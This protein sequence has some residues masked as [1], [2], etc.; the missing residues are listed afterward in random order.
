METPTLLSVTSP[1]AVA[2][3]GSMEF[4]A[5]AQAQ[6]CPSPVAAAAAQ[7]PRAGS[8]SDATSSACDAA[9]AKGGTRPER[10]ARFEA[11]VLVLS[12]LLLALFLSI[13]L[14]PDRPDAS[15]AAAVLLITALW[16]F[17]EIVPLTISSLL[18]LVLYPLLGVVKM[19]ELASRYFSGTSFLFVAGFFIGLAI[20]RWGLH[21]HF[22]C[23]IVSRAGSRIEFLIAGFMVSVWLLSM[24]ISNTAT[25]LCM[26]PVARGFL[27]T[28]PAGHEAFQG[29][30]LLAMGY[31]ATIGGIAT[32][33]GTPTNG[34]FMEQFEIFWPS[35]GEFS[36][37]KFFL[38][39]LPLSFVLLT[40]VWIG[41]CAVF[42]W[43]AKERIPIDREVFRGMQQELGKVTFDQ[44]VVAA[45]LLVLIVLWFTASPIGSFPGW[46]QYVASELNSGSIG[47][48]LT[49][50]LFLLPCGARLPASWR[51]LVGEERC[52]SRVPPAQG[53]QRARRILDWDMVK[54]SF[55]WE[56]LFVFGGGAA[57]AHGTVQS[58]LAAWVAENLGA[59]QTG[60]TAFLLMVASVICFVTEVVSNMATLSIFGSIIAATA[61]LK[62]YNPAQFLLVVTF[63][64]SFA[65][66]LP[67]AGGPN[68]VV[69]STGK[70]SVAEMAKYGLVL[71]LLAVVLG[72]LYMA[73]VM[74][75]LLGS[76]SD[77]PAPS[78]A[79]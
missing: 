19:S 46:K 33:V 28:M 39:A 66:M 73:F 43:G 9:E 17:T 23:C 12:A 63:A 24:W 69:Y 76:Y 21:S 52:L 16:W 72:G 74:P 54:G 51:R 15:K 27:D 10:S 45:D 20:E 68:M 78:A 11:G 30:F 22:A 26:I 49:L 4:D 42:V 48:A 59:V 40:I 14:D 38:C 50:P 13:D 70:V 57:I 1:R 3:G 41:F 2:A 47:L 36:F 31:S 25:I 58:G 29:A 55:Q 8:S 67:M 75:T 34:I 60:E 56:I 7:E 18:P 65:F 61:Q 32:P 64:S 53:E 79:A 44:M 5:E 62:G 6:C 35:E 37:A 77:L 71:N